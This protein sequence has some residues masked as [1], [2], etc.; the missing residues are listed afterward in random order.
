M[1]EMKLSELANLLLKD[2]VENYYNT[3]NAVFNIDT[4]K[5]NHPD[6]KDSFI[7]D[8][9]RLLKADGFVNVFW[10]D[11][12]AYF[13]SLLPNAVREADDDTLIRRGYAFLKEIRSWL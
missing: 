8:A 13:V 1:L 2:M 7:S 11:N 10:A 12:T 4:F 3:Q 5:Q 9:L 6:L